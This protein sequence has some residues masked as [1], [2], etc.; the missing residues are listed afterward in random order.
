[1]P[2]VVDGYEQTPLPGVSMRYSFD[3]AD[4]PTHKETQ[5]YEMLGTRGIW[6]KGWK[7][8]DRARAGAARSRQVRPGPLAA[9]PHRRGPL[10]GARPRRAAPGEARG[11]EGALARGGEEVRRPAAQRPRHLRVP[12]R[13]S[14][15]IAVPQ[16][17]QYTYYPGTS[18][19]PRGARPRTRTTSRTRSSPR[20]SSR[21][22][23]QG[24]IVAQ[25]SRFGGYSLFVKDG[26]L[27][28]VYNFLGIPPE[29]RI[30]GARAD[31]GHAHR[32]RSSSRRSGWATTTS[33]TG[34]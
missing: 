13:S 22:T 3:A 7:A 26:K 4:A 17:G 15:T 20:S 33:R 16:S 34:R 2:E 19:D 30:V 8:V 6:H 28:Y 21:R 12:R 29:Q 31:L 10:R 1:M 14:T 18:R 27:T 11:A 32:R 25:G 24:V 9:L 5:Y 23:P